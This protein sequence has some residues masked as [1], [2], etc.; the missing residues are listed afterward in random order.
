MTTQLPSSITSFLQTGLRPGEEYTV[1]LVA[2]KDQGRS[3]PVTATVTTSEGVK[4]PLYAPNVNATVT[5]KDCF[6][7]ASPRTEMERLLMIVLEFSLKRGC[8][9]L[10][11]KSTSLIRL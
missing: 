10:L 11:L 2:L 9:Q 5:A 7:I 6:A 8:H 4:H 1:N 3:Q